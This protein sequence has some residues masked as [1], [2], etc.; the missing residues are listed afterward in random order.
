MKT[1]LAAVLVLSCLLSTNARAAFKST[2]EIDSMLEKFMSLSKE[3]KPKEAAQTLLL[4][5]R[6]AAPKDLVE[7]SKGITEADVINIT[8]LGAITGAE[9]VT[10]CKIGKFLYRSQIVIKHEF[11]FVHWE[12]VFYNAGKEWSL[13]TYRFDNKDFIPLSRDCS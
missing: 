13:S 7:M 4:H 9:K 6:N 2:A 5:W 8:K 11:G 3:G 10:S 12:F 1:L